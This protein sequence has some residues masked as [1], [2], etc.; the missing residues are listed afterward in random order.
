MAYHVPHALLPSLEGRIHHQENLDGSNS[1]Q[2]SMEFKG[3]VD[4]NSETSSLSRRLL[5]V[6]NAAPRLERELAKFTADAKY[7]PQLHRTHTQQ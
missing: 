7:L 4:L 6:S 2:F 1:H 5:Q 3:D